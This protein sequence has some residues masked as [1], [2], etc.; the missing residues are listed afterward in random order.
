MGRGSLKYEKL[1]L[2]FLHGEK[3]EMKCL[4]KIKPLARIRCRG[5]SNIQ[6]YMK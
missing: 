3:V 6:A 4:R 1:C 5:Q 2:G